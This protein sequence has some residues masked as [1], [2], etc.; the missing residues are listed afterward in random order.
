MTRDKYDDDQ[1]PL[2]ADRVVEVE[3]DDPEALVGDPVE[4]EEE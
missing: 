3:D 1:E 2:K 4:D